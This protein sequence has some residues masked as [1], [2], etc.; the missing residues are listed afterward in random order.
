MPLKLKEKSL[1]ERAEERNNAYHN[2]KRFLSASM[3]QSKIQGRLFPLVRESVTFGGHCHTMLEGLLLGE[4]V[5]SVYKETTDN[6]KKVKACV[7]AAKMFLTPKI[8]GGSRLDCERPFLVPW[9][10][11]HA[12]VDKLES[13]QALPKCFKQHLALIEMYD[14]ESAGLKCKPD[15]L[16]NERGLFDWKFTTPS[17]MDSITGIYNTIHRYSY[18]VAAVHYALV[19]SAHF[20]YDV[21]I[22]EWTWVFCMKTKEMQ[23]PVLVKADL[24]STSFEKN[25]V[26]KLEWAKR[27]FDKDQLDSASSTDP[28]IVI[29]Y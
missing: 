5:P 18:I 11:I 28:T 19:V 24:L 6:G 1:V 25:W 26:Y 2:N 8:V 3:I 14:V 17:D 27:N 12:Y 9:D 29:D 15:L 22:T 23:R 4:E 21:P 7:G 10:T 13:R 16:E 20:N